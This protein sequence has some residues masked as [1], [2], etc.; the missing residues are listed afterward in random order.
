MANNIISSLVRSAVAAAG[1]A[2]PVPSECSQADPS[3]DDFEGIVAETR[4]AFRRRRN[5]DITEAGMFMW[6]FHCIIFIVEHFIELKFVCLV[7]NR[8]RK[9]G[10]FSGFGC[11]PEPAPK[12]N[13]V[14][15]HV[16]SCLSL[17]HS[18]T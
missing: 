6:G 18:L 12:Q 2:V 11:Q 13:I 7:L 5:L 17:V 8:I 15:V 10:A 16:V 1:S 4:R 9:S 14:Q 3:E